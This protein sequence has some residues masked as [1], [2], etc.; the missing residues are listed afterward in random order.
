M[1]NKVPFTVFSSLP[2]DNDLDKTIDKI[3]LMKQTNPEGYKAGMEDFNQQAM[4]E[5]ET[6]SRNAFIDM[7]S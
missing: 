1:D 5:Q 3:T 2:S 4:Q 6:K 7:E